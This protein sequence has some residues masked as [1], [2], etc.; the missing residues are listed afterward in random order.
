MTKC[1]SYCS[2]SQ[3]FR[4]WFRS[5]LDM[6]SVSL[7]FLFLYRMRPPFLQLSTVSPTCSGPQRLPFLVFW[8]ERVSLGILTSC[9]AC[10]FI[11]LGL[12]FRQN[13]RRK[14]RR[15]G[16]KII[17][18]FPRIFRP[19]CLLFPGPLARNMD[20]VVVVVLLVSKF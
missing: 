18:T 17:Q 9:S 13:S 1:V 2:A 5:V 7:G 19:Q 6:H 14:A 8:L 15:S 12:P 4:G 10:S 16:E 11:S 20:F 3:S